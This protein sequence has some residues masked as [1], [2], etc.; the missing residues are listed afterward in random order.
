MTLGGAIVN[1]IHTDAHAGDPPADLSAL[2]EREAGLSPALAGKV[3][4]AYA[5]EHALA[6]RDAANVAQL[7]ARLGAGVPLVRVPLL[8]GDVHDVDGLARLHAELFRDA[9]A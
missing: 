6:R 2:L 8:D 9:G 4:V 7:A 5:A 3:A 1:R